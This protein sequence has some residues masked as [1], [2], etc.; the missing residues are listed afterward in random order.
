[1]WSK[2]LL[3]P[4]SAHQE[5]LSFTEPP[6][7]DEEETHGDK[8]FLG[9]NQRSRLFD[10]HPDLQNKLHHETTTYQ[11]DEL[12]FDIVAAATVVAHGFVD[13][14]VKDVLRIAGLVE[15]SN[16]TADVKFC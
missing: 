10:C 16:K 13:L 5:G 11:L 12:A 3:S 1:M 8:S 14:R 15:A 6:L 4:S 2:K 7:K 9:D